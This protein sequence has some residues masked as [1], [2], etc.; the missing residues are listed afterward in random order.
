MIKGHLDK[1]GQTRLF[2]AYVAYEMKHFDDAAKWA[3]SVAA[4]SDVKSEDVGRLQ[5]AIKDAISECAADKIS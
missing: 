1:L 3:D 5:R 2:F 4:G